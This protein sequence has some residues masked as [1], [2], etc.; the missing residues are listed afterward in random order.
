MDAEIGPL[1]SDEMIS[2]L[3]SQAAVS[4]TPPHGLF[5]NIGGNPFRNF[6]LGGGCFIP[7]G[8]SLGAGSLGG[9]KDLGGHGPGGRDWMVAV[10]AGS[11][12]GRAAHAC[13][14]SGMAVAWCGAVMGNH[15]AA[16]P[17]TDGRAAGRFWEIGCLYL[18]YYYYHHLLCIYLAMEYMHVPL[19][20]QTILVHQTPPAV[21]TT[22]R[23]SPDTAS[24]NNST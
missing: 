13:S 22:P 11:L 12:A 20:P 19:W 8:S 18:Q 10:V 5:I 21:L 24:H 23:S 7:H 3:S 17:A 2:P 4:S 1:G 15:S 6:M 9:N 16:P 14:C